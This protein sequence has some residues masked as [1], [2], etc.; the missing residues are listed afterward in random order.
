MARR[1]Y[2]FAE[3]TIGRLA[4]RNYYT[5]KAY[6]YY[7]LARADRRYKGPPP[8]LVYQMG[9]VGSK[10]VTESLKMAKIGR[11]IYH[12]HLL[13]TETLDENERKYKAFTPHVGGDLKYVWRSQYIRM[14]VDRG[15][16]GEKW[17]ILTLVRDP[18]ARNLPTFF[19]TFEWNQDL[20]G[21]GNSSRTG[22][23]LRSPSTKIVPRSWLSVSLKGSGMISP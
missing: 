4:Q 17:K 2:R 9:K 8:L 13:A 5:A 7:K 19:S 14:R 12:I 23:T 10:T 15:L 18:V 20:I 1:V 21:N 22:M 3:R 6:Y 11:P 16:N